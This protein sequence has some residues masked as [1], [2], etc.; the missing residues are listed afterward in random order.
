MPVRLFSL[1]ILLLLLQTGSLSADD[2]NPEYDRPTYRLENR[3][4]KRL[5]NLDAFFYPWK[6]VGKITIDSIKVQRHN[7][8]L[9]VY[10][11][12]FITHIPI[13]YPFALALET[14]IRN[15]LGRRF[16]KYEI[17]LIARGKHLTSFIPNYFRNDHQPQDLL[18]VRDRQKTEFALVKRISPLEFTSGLSGNHIA[19]WNSHGKYYNA[20]KDRWQWQRARLFSTVEDIFLLNMYFVTLPQCSKMQVPMF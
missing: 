10:F 8:Q 20:A 3:A 15:Q 5:S 9:T 12:P 7:E 1:V 2:Q 16:R 11:N 14:E 6:H 17:N 18:R 19:I 4:N 13:R